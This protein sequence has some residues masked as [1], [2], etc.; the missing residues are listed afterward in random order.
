M[1][2]QT[3]TIIAVIAVTASVTILLRAFPFLL[4]STGRKC[5]PVITYIGKV[6][7]PAA[8]A[9]LV[10]YCLCSE[11]RDRP[12]SK[13]GYGLPELTASAI[14]IALHWWKK[15]PLLSII[16]GTAVYMLMV[17]CFFC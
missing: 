7:S 10:I 13:A 6:L 17:Q 1:N 4:F 16:S 2:P 3:V 12:F 14:V 15:N 8:I 9:M 5:P 11:F